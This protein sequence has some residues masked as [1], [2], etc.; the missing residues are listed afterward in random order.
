MQ[1]REDKRVDVSQM[2]Y[3]ELWAIQQMVIAALIVL[4]DL[5]LL[6]AFEDEARHDHTG[7]G[8]TAG[9]SIISIIPFFSV[10]AIFVW[11]LTPPGV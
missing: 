10:F 1:V 11:V 3:R 2:T 8:T 7:V 6:L 4:I 9:V 5:C